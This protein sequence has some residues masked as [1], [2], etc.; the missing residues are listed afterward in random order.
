M[1][2]SYTQLSRLRVSIPLLVSPRALLESS[3]GLVCIQRP[4]VAVNRCKKRL[5]SSARDHDSCP[6]VRFQ[7][8]HRLA[9]RTC[10][11]T[12]GTSG[13]G[14]AIAERFLQEGASTI[15]LVGRSHERLVDAAA[16]LNDYATTKTNSNE[17]RC[18]DAAVAPEEDRQTR[19]DS[20]IP[21]K[22]HILVGDVSNASTWTRE[23][24][25]ELVL[26]PNIP[27]DPQF[28]QCTGRGRHLGQRSGHFH[29]QHPPE[30]RSRRHRKDSTHQSRRGNT[31]ISSI[32][33]G[34]NP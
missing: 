6:A 25:K 22:I 29:L 17:T 31:H 15:I 28:N 18:D 11:I 24:E 26:I 27:I 2:R 16:R 12:G 13:I 32:H 7:P 23:L 14:Y 9:G 1:A 8:A 33:A 34:R 19:T 21:E 20:K 30:M 4:S 3:H 5:M 10:L